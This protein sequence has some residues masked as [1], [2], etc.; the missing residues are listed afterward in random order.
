MG[1]IFNIGDILKAN[2]KAQGMVEGRLYTVDS[3]TSEV[4]PFGTFVRYVLRDGSKLIT[5][6]NAHFLLSKVG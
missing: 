6:G 1:T 4:L 2:V 5:V 3:I